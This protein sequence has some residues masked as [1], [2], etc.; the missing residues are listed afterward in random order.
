MGPTGTP[1][2]AT[3]HLGQARTIQMLA[4]S[5]QLPACGEGKYLGFFLGTGSSVERTFAALTEKT[6]KRLQ[7]WSHS[8]LGL[9]DKIRIWN[10]F[11]NSLFGYPGQLRRLPDRQSKE[12]QSALMK[13][14]GYR[15]F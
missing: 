13:W 11:I 14:I 8:R 2:D 3:A 15:N 4:V 9:F 5:N 10:V 6:R 1:A 7:Q 12:T